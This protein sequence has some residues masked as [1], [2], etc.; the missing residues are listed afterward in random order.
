MRVFANVRRITFPAAGKTARHGRFMFNQYSRLCR[1][2]LRSCKRLQ[3]T[4]AGLI[5]L[6][7]WSKVAEA[8]A[9]IGALLA[10]LSSYWAVVA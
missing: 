10:G 3:T 4:E 9:G 2:N 6:I 8:Q 7:A 5:M 1:G